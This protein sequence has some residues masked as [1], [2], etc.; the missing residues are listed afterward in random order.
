MSKRTNKIVNEVIEQIV[1]LLSTKYGINSEN[2]RKD[3]KEVPTHL[4]CQ[5]INK[6]TGRK[7]G[8]ILCIHH[9]QEEKKEKE[10]NNSEYF[11]KEYSTI[12]KGLDDVIKESIMFS[13]IDSTRRENNM[14]TLGF[15]EKYKLDF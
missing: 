15:S 11:P 13:N 3:I 7:C 9:K 14:P 12:Y 2:V 10:E 5:Y 6:K 8:V 4:E 1:Y